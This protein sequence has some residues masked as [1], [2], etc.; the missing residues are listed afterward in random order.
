M[1]QFYIEQLNQK[2]TAALQCAA[3]RRQNVSV[4]VHQKRTLFAGVFYPTTHQRRLGVFWAVYQFQ[5]C[6]CDYG[7]D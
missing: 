5:D 1:N 4:V 7:F 6:V 3:A 2:I